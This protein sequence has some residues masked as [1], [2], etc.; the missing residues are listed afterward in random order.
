MSKHKKVGDEKT[1]VGKA[2]SPPSGT[3][4][5]K[6]RDEKDKRASLPKVSK[7][8]VGGGDEK[9]GGLH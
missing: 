3:E 5:E 6:P 4:N 1:K 7:K 8:D 2:G 9:G